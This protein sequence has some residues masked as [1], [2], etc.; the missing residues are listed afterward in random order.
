MKLTTDRYEALHS[1]SVI[2]VLLVYKYRQVAGDYSSCESDDDTAHN[3]RELLDMEDLG[4]VLAV[5]KKTKVYTL[6]TFGKQI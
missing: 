1:L 5:A 4:N 2:A 6:F 3:D